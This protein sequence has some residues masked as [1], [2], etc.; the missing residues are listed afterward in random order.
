MATAAAD[1]NA[2]TRRALT[3]FTT[4]DPFSLPVTF[5]DALGHLTTIDYDDRGAPTRFADEL[6]T[7]FRFT[8]SEQGVPLT[9]DDAEGKRAFL[10]YDDGGN[11]TNI[12]APASSGARPR[13]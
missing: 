10:T 11:V 6:G 1:V 4:Y 3:T 8:S 13:A 12:T 7:R 2:A 5:K 9:V